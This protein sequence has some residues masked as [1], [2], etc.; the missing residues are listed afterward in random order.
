MSLPWIISSIS[1]SVNF[2]PRFLKTSFISLPVMRS[3]PF[4]SKT[5]K[6]SISS[7]SVSASYIF[8]CIKTKNSWKSIEPFPSASHS[9]IISTSSVSVGFCPNDFITVPNS[10]VEIVPSPSLSKSENASLNSAIYSSVRLS[11]IYYNK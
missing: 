5:L 10:F 1:S 9:F 6:D 4:R 11:A 2:S 3:S 8:L 7:S